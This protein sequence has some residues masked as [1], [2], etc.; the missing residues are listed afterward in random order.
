VQ[1]FPAGPPLT[2]ARLDLEP[3]RV[4]HAEEMSPL[5]NDPA[6]HVFIGG[7]PASLADLREQYRRQAVGRS[8][9]GSQRWLNWVARRRED[10]RAVGTVQATLTLKDET[11]VAEIAWVLA[12]PHQSQ[13]YARE[14]AGSRRLAA[15]T[16]QQLVAHIPPPPGVQAVAVAIGLTATTT[17]VDGETRW[18]S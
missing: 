14:A 11:L 7:E 9:D 1:A 10:G 4:E 13:G 8:A 3:L 2:S 18:Q 6:L 12:T 16:R 5:L 17:V 15:D